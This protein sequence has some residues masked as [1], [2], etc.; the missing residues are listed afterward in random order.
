MLPSAGVPVPQPGLT[1]SGGAFLAPHLSFPLQPA[2]KL[3]AERPS[4]SCAWFL[5]AALR[6]PRDE[7]SRS[8]GRQR[9]E[10]GVPRPSCP[11]P[12]PPSAPGPRRGGIRD[13]GAGRGLP[14]PHPRGPGGGRGSA[15][16]GRARQRRPGN[17][18]GCSGGSDRGR[19][20]E[21]E[22]CAE[23]GK[24]GRENPPPTRGGCRRDK[25]AAARGGRLDG[26]ERDPRR[27]ARRCPR[28]G[29]G[30]WRRARRARPS[31]AVAAAAEP[32]HGTGRGAGPA[33][34][35]PRRPPA[36][37][38]RV[39]RGMRGAAPLRARQPGPPAQ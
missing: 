13:P 33:P 7:L 23:R 36:C 20:K 27:A 11:A 31:E 12:V 32:G 8:P 28:G 9:P 29:G 6:R 16:I 15:A 19:R 17:G 39:P 2:G 37:P 30:S 21:P 14:A 3:S 5:P 18:S 26:A 22:E 24:G 1:L 25:A 10:R 38:G 35:S 4:G 34:A